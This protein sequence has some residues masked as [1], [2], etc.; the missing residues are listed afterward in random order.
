MFHCASR[1]FHDTFVY[2]SSF[3]RYALSLCVKISLRF[4]NEN[5]WTAES[6]PALHSTPVCV[7]HIWSSKA[8]RIALSKA[9]DPRTQRGAWREAA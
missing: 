8:Q 1:S 7:S 6:A 9:A 3:R 5:Q 4:V 2:V